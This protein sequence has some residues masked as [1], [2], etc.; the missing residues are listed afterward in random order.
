MSSR[1]DQ[2]FVHYAKAEEAM[3]YLPKTCPEIPEV[4]EEHLFSA[5]S[6][7]DK[8]RRERK[9][10]VGESDR[11]LYPLDPASPDDDGNDTVDRDTLDE[12]A[13]PKLELTH[14]STNLCIEEPQGSFRSSPSTLACLQNSCRVNLSEHRSLKKN[15]RSRRLLSQKNSASTGFL[16]MDRTSNETPRGYATDRPRATPVTYKGSREESQRGSFNDFAWSQ[17]DSSQRI[18]QRFLAPKAGSTAAVPTL[19][20]KNSERAFSGI[21]LN[22][23]PTKGLSGCATYCSERLRQPGGLR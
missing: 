12:R 11:H 10:S 17:R 7:D 9:Y 20:R 19:K 18:W 22:T 23:V 14:R 5:T 15:S 2:L 6:S 3:V 8:A 21:H 13:W 16:S 4:E 1:V